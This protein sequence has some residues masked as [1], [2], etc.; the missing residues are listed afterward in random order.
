MFI[1]TA[2]AQ[3]H[4][5]PDSQVVPAASTFNRGSPIANNVAPCQFPDAPVN[6]CESAY[7]SATDEER[8]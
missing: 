6:N 1:A 8:I 4:S 5:T 3:G 2:A 7:F